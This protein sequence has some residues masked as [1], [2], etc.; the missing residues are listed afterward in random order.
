MVPMQI[1]HLL[2]GRPWQYNRDVSHAG[3]RNQYFIQMG[4]L[5]LVLTAL[6]RRDAY[7]DQLKIIK[8]YDEFIKRQ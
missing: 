4:S 3:E 6:S 7:E 8:S 2:L 1:G 5:T